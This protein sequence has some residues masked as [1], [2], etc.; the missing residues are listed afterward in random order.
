MK[1]FKIVLLVVVAAVLLAGAYFFGMKSGADLVRNGLIANYPTVKNVV[2]GT[3]IEVDSVASVT[4]AKAENEELFQLLGGDAKADTLNFSIPYYGRYG[5]PSV[6][7]FRVLKNG[8]GEV[9][10]WMPPAKMQYCELKF[11]GMFI[12]GKPATAV[13]R[14]ENTVELKRKLYDFL[15]PVLNKNKGNLKAAKLSATK[16]LMFYFIPY[17]FDLKVYIDNDIQDL[18]VVPGVNQS[19]DEAIKKAIGK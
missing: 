9:E 14:D 4:L 18:P 8:D 19:V 10:V 1:G 16:A 6:G 3:S 12:N 17:K 15:I 7:P 13:V 11:D 2:Q 5:V